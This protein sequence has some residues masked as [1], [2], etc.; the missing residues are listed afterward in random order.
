[1]ILPVSH[2]IINERVI[3][4]FV[5]IIIVSARHT[6]SLIIICIELI[7]GRSQ[8]SMERRLPASQQWGKSKIPNAAAKL[9]PPALKE[10]TLREYQRT[11]PSTQR[12]RR[13]RVLCPPSPRAPFFSPLPPEHAGVTGGP[14]WCWQGGSRPSPLERLLGALAW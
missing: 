4:V 1:M 7:G 2:I 12:C 9:A 8:W 13:S 10:K 3:H 14:S 5:I 11:P 6:K